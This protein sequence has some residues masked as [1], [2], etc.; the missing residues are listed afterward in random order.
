ML[1]GR[2]SITFALLLRNHKKMRNYCETIPRVYTQV[3]FWV[4]YGKILGNKMSN[5]VHLSIGSI[6]VQSLNAYLLTRYGIRRY[7]ILLYYIAYIL[8]QKYHYFFIYIFKPMFQKINSQE[9]EFYQ[10][11]IHFA[12]KHKI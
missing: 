5:N 4:T 1:C 11:K 3:I 12:S 6:A 8:T 9:T 10:T 7:P 2:L